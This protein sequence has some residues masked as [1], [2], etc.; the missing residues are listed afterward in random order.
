MGLREPSA[1][2]PQMPSVPQ[3]FTATP[4]DG[5]VALSWSAPASDGGSAILKYQVS[6]DNGTSWTDVG[7]NTSHTFTGLTNG[8]EYTFRG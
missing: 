4:G 1:E 8:T 6:K 5:Q 7:L 2:A 3:N